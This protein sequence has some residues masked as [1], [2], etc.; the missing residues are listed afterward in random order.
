MFESLKSKLI[1]YPSLVSP[2]WCRGGH[3]H[4]LVA[5]FAP[6]EKKD[7]GFYRFSIDTKD[8]DSLVCY[9]HKGTTNKIVLLFHGL[10]G[11]SYSGYMVRLGNRFARQGHQ[12][13]LVNHRGAHPE[14]SK[15]KEIYH[16]GRSEDISTVIEWVRNYKSE[17]YQIAIG[18]SMSANIVLL[19]RAGVRSPHQ[20][21][22]T[23]AVNAPID[24]G[25]AARRLDE[26]F[27][28]AYGLFFTKQL[29]QMSQTERWPVSVREF[30]E[31]FTSQRAGYKSA[32]DY[33]DQCSAK[34]YL[35][36]ITRPTLV[37]TA[38]DDPFISSSIYQQLAWPSS[39]AIRIEKEG[40]HLG[41]IQKAQTRSWSWMDEYLDFVVNLGVGLGNSGH[42]DIMNVL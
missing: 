42:D 7:P 6:Q 18:F 13:L 10:A 35:H 11:S 40:G 21:D 41:Y 19:N 31:K 34:K 39:V 1:S 12:V 38:E 14:L 16:S 17:L 3:F 25:D 22:F 23:V 2:F 4:T 33:Y 29:V 15:S 30:D 37:L 26:G 36:Q 9:H 5:H 24:L 28:K 8:G 32:H 20:P 27:N